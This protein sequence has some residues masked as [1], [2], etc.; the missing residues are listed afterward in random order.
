[1]KTMAKA[2]MTR[3]SSRKMNLVAALIRGQSASEATITLAHTNKAAADVVGKVLASAIANAENNHNLKRQ[4]LTVESVLVGAGP[5]L[6]RSRSRSRGQVHRIL[7][8]TSH[9]TIILNDDKANPAKATKPVAEETPVIEAAKP[10]AQK[11]AAK[12]EAK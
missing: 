2:K 10:T 4:D 7:K 3:T 6:K 12:K 5:T 9:L 8:R 1:M 11:P